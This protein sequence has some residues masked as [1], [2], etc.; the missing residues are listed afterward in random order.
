MTQR[1]GHNEGTIYKRPNCSFQAQITLPNGKRKTYTAKTKREVQKLLYGA[2]VE[3]TQGRLAHGPRQTVKKYLDNW[4]E[5][6]RESVRQRTTDAYALNIQRLARHIGHLHLDAL[7]PS[8]IQDCY[9]Q[10]SDEGLAPRTILQV[11]RV[12]HEALKHAVKLELIGRNPTEVVIPPRPAPVQYTTLSADQVKTLLET[13]RE[14]H[15][16]AL[17]VLLVTTGLRFG[18]ASGLTWDDLELDTGKV[19]VRRQLQRADGRKAAFCEPKTAQSR[20]TLP[21]SQVACSALREHRI[22]QLE[23]RLAA[24]GAWEV[25]GEY[26]ALVFRHPNG[27]PLDRA[28]TRDALKAALK[29]AALPAI[30][31]HDLRH[32]AATLLFTEAQMHPKKVQALLGHSTYALTMNTYT[33]VIPSALDDV[34]D[35]MERLFGAADAVS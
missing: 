9:R 10:L 22:R 5:L 30:R 8:D 7:K 28:R 26:E 3:L 13:T 6:K 2:R 17:W 12:L 35:S 29:R 1:R 19:T 31:V 15:L 20:R 21:L 27:A 16:H 11:H 33:H 25:Y 23:T 24:G 32:T 18:E 4:L 14:D 34:A